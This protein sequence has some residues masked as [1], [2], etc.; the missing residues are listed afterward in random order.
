[1]ADKVSVSGSTSR[2]GWGIGTGPGYYQVSS[3]YTWV[4]EPGQAFAELAVAYQEALHQAVMQICLKWAPKIENWIK[5]NA[6]WTDRTGNA[7]QTLKVEVEDVVNE[8][9]SIV[10]WHGMH[11]GLFLEVKNA[12]RYAIVNPAIDEFGTKVW[13]DVRRMV[14]A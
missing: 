11:Y 7:R 10:L 6:P 9:V 13:A 5:D 4:V 1:M 8:M 3:G 2:V 14:G 12:G